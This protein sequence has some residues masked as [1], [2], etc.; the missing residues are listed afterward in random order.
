V[1]AQCVVTSSLVD[2]VSIPSWEKGSGIVTIQDPDAVRL[3][4][5]NMDH[6]IHVIVQL[7]SHSDMETVIMALHLVNASFRRSN[8]IPEGFCFRQLFEECSRLDALDSTCDHVASIKSASS[9]NNISWFANEMAA[10]L[11]D[12]CFRK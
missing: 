2:A 1:S 8:M 6:R 3:A 10:D 7:L 9:S 4:F 11:I 12:G 5:L